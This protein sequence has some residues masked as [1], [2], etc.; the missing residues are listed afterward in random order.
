MDNNVFFG[1]FDIV[2]M[3]VDVLVGWGRVEVFI[4]EIIKIFIDSIGDGF[5]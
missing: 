5:G 4:E 2:V 1:G 3:V